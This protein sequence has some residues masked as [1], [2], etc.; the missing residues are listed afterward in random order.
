MVSLPF[1]FSNQPGWRLARHISFWFLWYVFQVMLYAF[2][3][4][5]KLLALP[6]LTRMIMVAP[7][8]LCYL[9]VHIFLAYSLMY[10]VI[11]RL[12]IPGRYVLAAGTVILVL[13]ATAALSAFLSLTVI[14][15]L[16]RGYYPKPVYVQLFM[17]MIAGLRGGITIGGLAAAIKLMKHYYEKQ[18]LASQLEKQNM[19]AELQTLKSQLHPHFLFNTLNNIY[20]HAQETA[21]IAADMLLGLSGLLRYMLYT[22]NAPLVPLADEIKMIQAYINLEKKRY[23]EELELSIQLPGNTENLMIAPLIM[24]PFVENCFKHGTS[25]VL[26]NPWINLNI[27]LKDQ[28]MQLKLVNGKADKMHAQEGGIGIEN[29]RRRLT[30]IYPEKHKLTI[31]E[32]DELYIVN[33]E[34]KLAAR[35]EPQ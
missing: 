31:M 34:I 8:S 11:P 7:E 20:S 9:S 12:I 6:F 14:E 18:Q 16:R 1:V 30:L 3:P 17:S 26:E 22:G 19:L 35:P 5:P 32:E 23:G 2:A 21:P 28:E 33:L 4:E 24:L 27:A 25:S 15:Y 10:W 29:V 13:L